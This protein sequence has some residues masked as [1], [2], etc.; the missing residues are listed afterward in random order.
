MYAS[1][2]CFTCVLFGVGYEF[3]NCLSFQVIEI[4]A[5]LPPML[6]TQEEARQSTPAGT[7]TSITVNEVA[8]IG[9]K[10]QQAEPA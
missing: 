1:A 8:V 2:V 7:V 4:T 5:P 3:I 6:Q 10:K 9:E